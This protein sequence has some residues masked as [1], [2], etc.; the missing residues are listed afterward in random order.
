MA[1]Q[2]ALLQPVL[3][4]LKHYKII[5]IADR[6]F[7]SVKLANWL[8][9]KRVFFALRQKKDTYIQ[10]QGQEFQRLITLKLKPGIS[11]YLTQVQ[12]TKQ[13]GFAKF[14]LAAYWRRSYRGR[15]VDEPWYI[16]TNLG[17]KEAAIAAF[18]ARFG[19]EAMFKDCKSG[20]YHLEDSH[21]SAQR[22]ITLVLLIAIAYSCATLYGHKLK[23]MG[24][25]KY[26]S[27]VK[28]LKRLYRRHS[29]FW[30]G[31]YG[32]LWV[33]GMEI[34]SPLAT[35]LMHLKPHKLND[36]KRGLMAMQLIQSTL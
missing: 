18:K 30:V 28:E 31:L 8:S 3:Q 22:L 25:Q 6:E 2:K 36:F 33:A 23:H 35:R 34:W 21:A 24:L 1:E 19:I 15:T 32:Q 20:G 5:L 14:D 17:S 12:F 13:R 16:L 26:I 4:L 27:R 11:L 10:Q 7:H 9:T 29:S